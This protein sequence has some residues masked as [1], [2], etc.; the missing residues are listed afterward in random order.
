MVIPGPVNE[1]GHELGRNRATARERILYGKFR[2][3][4]DDL[5]INSVVIKILFI[6]TTTRETS[7]S[8]Q[9]ERH[10]TYYFILGVGNET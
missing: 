4:T 10:S 5:P 9:Y 8:I 7:G 1:R 2:K 6:D 3:L